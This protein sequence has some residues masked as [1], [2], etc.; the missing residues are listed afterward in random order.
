M[1]GFFSKSQGEKKAEPNTLADR[2]NL[3]REDFNKRPENQQKA[4]SNK[5]VQN[6]MSNDADMPSYI[7]F[8]NMSD[9]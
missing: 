7:S 2:G 1:D 5:H 8:V 4:F 9:D 3:G 6:V